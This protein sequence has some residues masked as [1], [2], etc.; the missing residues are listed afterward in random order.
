M[1][2]ILTLS[3]CIGGASAALS[4]GLSDAVIKIMGSGLAAATRNTAELL[5]NN[6]QRQC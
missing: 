3:I 5:T 6:N 4:G 1:W 2:Q